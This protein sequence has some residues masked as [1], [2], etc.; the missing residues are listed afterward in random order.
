MENI[1]FVI[2]DDLDLSNIFTEALK[3][4][5]YQVETIRDGAVARQRL[6]EATPE[7]IILDLHL[8]NVDGGALL[9]QVRADERLTKTR[10]IIATADALL[11]EYYEKK[12][13]L[14]LVKPISFSQLRDLT[15]RY[16]KK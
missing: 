8:P 11:G 12:A 3:A 14:V 13:D 7:I 16:R 1:A 5:G 9:T 6:K 10:V 15:A 4:A 2:E